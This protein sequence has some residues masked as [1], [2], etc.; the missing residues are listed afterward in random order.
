MVLVS[1]FRSFREPTVSV[2]LVCDDWDSCPTKGMTT[3][4]WVLTTQFSP[5][6]FLA[7]IFIVLLYESFVGG[8]RS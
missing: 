4:V 6:E 7:R 3:K 8:Y 2:D 5:G 1:T